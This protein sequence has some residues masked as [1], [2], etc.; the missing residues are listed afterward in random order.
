MI[1]TKVFHMN[2]LACLTRTA[3]N[4]GSLPKNWFTLDIVLAYD[5]PRR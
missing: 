1:F 3:A 2:T 5:F 4:H